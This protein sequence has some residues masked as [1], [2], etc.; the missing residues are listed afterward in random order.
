MDFIVGEHHLKDG[1]RSEA[2]SNYRRSFQALQLLSSSNQMKAEKW[3]TMQIRARLDELA[4]PAEPA[5]DASIVDGG[6]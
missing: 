2:L 5:D 3:L 1:N 4:A 6:G